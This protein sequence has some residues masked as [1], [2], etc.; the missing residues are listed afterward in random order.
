MT[1]P[2]HDIDWRTH[3]VRIVRAG[4]LDL[5]TAQTPGMTRAA[6]I[7]HAKAGANKLWA[8]TV[9]VAPN[10]KTGAHHHG[11][12]ESII[13]V[14]KGRAR[15]RW[16]ERLEFMAEAEAGDFI[17]VPPYVPHQEINALEGEH[18]RMRDRPQ[19]PGGGRRQPRNRAGRGG[20]GGPLGRPEPPGG[21]STRLEIISDPVCPWCYLGAANLM[22]AIA[23]SDAHPFALSWR[24]YQLDPDLPP[25]GIDR[26]AHMA[27]KFPDAAGLE[28]A[29]ARIAAMGAVSGITYNFNRIVRA[30]NTIDAHRVI[31]WAAAEGLQTRTAM[32]LFRRYFELGEDI[33]DPGVLTAAAA[34]A[35]LDPV[36][37]GQLLAGDAE[38]EE[39]RAEAGAAR[40][41]GVTGVP[42]F[43]LGGRYAI[44]GAQPPEFWEELI[45]RIEAA[46]PAGS[47]RMSRQ[48]HGGIRSYTDHAQR[49]HKACTRKASPS[50]LTP[51]V[52]MVPP[53]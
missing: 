34:E 27:G 12:L 14:V 42:T 22:R 6:A 30:P 40:E 49:M 3:G 45:G 25:E 11:H 19:R 17:F 44:S 1:E 7:N 28:R 13:Y 8:G 46:A 24:P 20:R 23:A 39:V 48:S 31:H 26:A 16:G 9:S 51:G 32:A 15:M 2:A 35:G 36:V 47:I 18:A 5:N 52:R 50:L 38:R 53:C 37:I 41:M 33:S 10:A 21:M 4:E 43:I 29:H